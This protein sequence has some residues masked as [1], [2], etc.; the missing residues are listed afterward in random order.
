MPI[1][2]STARKNLLTL[3]QHQLAKQEFG[4]LRLA[5]WY[6]IEE[7][8]SDLFLFEVF[9]AFRTPYGNET[10][11]FRF[12]GMGFLWLPGLYHVTVCSLAFFQQAA[13]LNDDD[14]L[15]FRTQLAAGNAEI[16]IPSLPTQDDDITK[17]LIA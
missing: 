11:T 10:A 17:F 16:L 3:L 2:R 4:A 1:D 15:K 6:D 9:E 12:P 14:L 13:Q 7:Q 5:L 8:A